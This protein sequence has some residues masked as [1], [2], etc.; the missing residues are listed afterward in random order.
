MIVS[1]FK[2]SFALYF[3]INIL[4]ISK[5]ATGWVLEINK[6][7]VYCFQ[8]PLFNN[9]LIPFTHDLSIEFDWIVN[10]ENGPLRFFIIIDLATFF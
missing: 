7:S 9:E 8:M 10:Y 2:F 6:R 4:N 5:T 3:T 1:L